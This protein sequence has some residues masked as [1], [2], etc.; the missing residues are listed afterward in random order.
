MSLIKNIRMPWFV[1]KGADLQLRLETFNLFNSTNL[2]NPDNNM[3]SPLFGKSTSA[4]PGRVV[5]FA[6]RLSF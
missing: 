2:D 3:S 6:A 5:Q 4:Q 1:G